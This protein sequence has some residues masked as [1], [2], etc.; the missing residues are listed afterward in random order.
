M[1]PE[2]LRKNIKDARA[3]GTIP[4]FVNATA[5]TTV[6]GSIDPLEDIAA[7]C[8]QENLWFHID[9]RFIYW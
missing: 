3:R 7:I 4:F 9:V 2:D 8:K 6:V 1:D 5:G